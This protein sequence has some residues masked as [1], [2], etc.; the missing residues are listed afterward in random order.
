MNANTPNAKSTDDLAISLVGKTVGP[1]QMAKYIDRGASALVFEAQDAAGRKVAVKVFDPEFIEKY[2]DEVQIKRIE[3]QLLLKGEHH[4]HL[5]E[6]CATTGLYYLVMPFLPVPSLEK[7]LE[8][9]PRENIWSIISQV[10]EAAQFLEGLNMCHR[11]IKPANIAVIGS[12][13]NNAILLDLGVVRP[14]GLRDLTDTTNTKEFVGTTRYS[15]PEFLLRDE[16][17]SLQGF[18]T[19]TFYQLGGVLHDL[20]MRRPLFHDKVKPYARLVRAVLLEE[21]VIEATDVPPELVRLAR[22][23]LV[24]DPERRFQS[25]DWTAFIPRPPRLP[26]IDDA[27]HRAEK[28]RGAITSGPPHAADPRVRERLKA[29]IIDLREQLKQVCLDDKEMFPAVAVAEHDRSAR[30]AII[31]L[32]FASSSRHA[33][34][35]QMTCIYRIDLFDEAAWTFAVQ[36]A[37]AVQFGFAK[38]ELW[39]APF[40]SLGEAVAEKELLEV[41]VRATYAAMVAALEEFA[42]GVS[43]ATPKWIAIEG[44]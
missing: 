30:S 25:L 39:A 29:V 1:F 14:L 23:C 13:Y 33:L 9:V 36:A 19:V 42:T 17:D 5:I 16:D 32:Q 12:N 3:R 20:I 38:I 11:D 41:C 22:L 18:R 40:K 27:R 10:A 28:L 26:A 6:Q 44:T 43:S 4:K 8:K 21:P 24:K 7:V 34:P 15:P 31:S 2:D 35:Q 37:V